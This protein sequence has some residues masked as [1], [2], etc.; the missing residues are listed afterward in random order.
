[1]AHSNPGAL[2][3]GSKPEI[4]GS[5]LDYGRR[6]VP[7]IID[8]RARMGYAKPY[9][10][11]PRS[12]DVS[13]GFRDVSYRELANAI[14]R[15]AWWLE[16]KLGRSDG[17][18]TLAYIGPTDLRYII[19]TVATIKTGYKAFFTSPRNS[20]EGHEALF[21]ENNVKS[22]L[23][24]AAAPP[25]V[26]S[27]LAKRPTPTLVVPELEEWLDGEDVPT[28]PYNKTY[29]EARY[30]PFIALHTSGS[31]GF[32]KTVV[33]T[34]GTIAVIDAY[35]K[36][37]SL[38]APPTIFD[39][40]KNTKIFVP[41]PPFHSAGICMILPMTVYLEMTIV[42]APA[43]PLTAEVA[44]AVHTFSG[45]EGSVLPSSVLADLVKVPEFLQNMNRLKY[46]SFG[47]GPLP[48][49]VGEAVR[50]V[51]RPI[52]MIGA[53]ETSPL[54]TEL[55]EN[56]DWQY[57]RFSP[58]LGFEFRHFAGDLY[59]AVVVQDQKLDLFQGVF[60]TYPHLKEYPMKDLYSRHPTDPRLWLYRG[61]ADDIIVFVNGE[62]LN[63]VTM[64]GVISSHP[65]VKGALVVGQG[66]FQSALLIEPRDDLETETQRRDFVERLWPTIERANREC[67]AHGRLAKELIIFTSAEKP[68]LRAGK[69]TIQRKLTVDLY[70]QEF[71]E[72]YSA[73]ET[74]SGERD[75]V[76]DTNDLAS[77]QASLR[78]LIT[79]I[80][81][82]E[83]PSDDA[84]FFSLGVDSLHVIAISRQVNNALGRLDK[85]N[86]I[87]PKT[88][89]ANPT[90]KKLAS[91][92]LSSANNVNRGAT[93]KP[94]DR[95]EKMKSYLEQYG[96]DLPITARP[97]AQSQ[98]SDKLTVVLTG[99]TGSLGSY[100][101]DGLL[102]D[103][104]VTK[105][106]CL[107]RRADAEERQKKI[108]KA[109]GL[110][111]WSDSDVEFLQ[112]NFSKEYF[113]L[114]PNTYLE[115][116]QEATHI[117]HNAWEVDFNLAIESFAGVHI[118]G[119]RQLIDFSSRSAKR[120]SIFFV[121]SIGTAMNW[122]DKHSGEVPETILEDWDMPQAMGYAESKYV[123]ERLLDEASR[124]ADIPASICRVGQIAGPTTKQGMWNK[125][126]WF[127][128][129]VA[130]SKY[131]GKLPL[132]LGSLDKIDW[133][134][135]DILA[136]V[137]LQLLKGDR[138]HP[139]E[140]NGLNGTNGTNGANGHGHHTAQHSNGARVYHTVN[141]SKTSWTS[142]LPSVQKHL[143]SA[144]D[145]VSLEQ[146]LAALR[147]SSG[148]TPDIN[149]NPG[150]K[151]IDFYESLVPSAGRTEPSLAT[152]KT[153]L[154]SNVLADLEPV[155]AQW[156]E[157]WMR[158]WSF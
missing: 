71:D 41:F 31:T 124:I 21:A 33:M 129:I 106:Y 73:F 62:K 59:E 54:A 127:P 133:I 10:S 95:L 110:C 108:H 83:I 9:A 61:R 138:S 24:P 63:P 3:K 157:T 35:Q 94:E 128:S 17:F 51:T 45:A 117:L 123:A 77:L 64:E 121:S 119:V 139:N 112:C 69:G 8:E 29:E 4:M 134:P 120:A 111:G 96:T 48:K 102:A 99:S 74:G 75:L 5:D 68:M 57:F 144:L 132:S 151:L 40:L 44:D 88:I 46:V 104:Q 47:G 56:D 146:W 60:S 26:K 101:L 140:V 82:L 97:F 122:G 158:Q 42:M 141:P 100:L 23:F 30:E 125:Q 28:Y 43:A 149:A 55:V 18:E 39:Q 92:L 126:E 155:N 81:R 87:A 91:A 114:S 150:V 72:L 19:L 37:S 13:L 143:G 36:I 107:N 131:L 98:S 22:F 16:E 85:S 65:E 93:T 148:G 53:T 32:P 14:N 152:S 136:K 147:D 7:T 67:V 38:G 145:V 6:L 135:V 113:G 34:N 90:I 156:M 153:T 76:L 115:L 118:R 49:E 86:A 70:K 50:T 105:V 78:Q 89:Y 130:S 154:H 12:T 1:M 2:S 52:N 25:V 137:L 11:I 79:E 84:E 58:Y 66:Q 109:R 116:L 103:P 80:S 27:I 20:I 142:L 15:C